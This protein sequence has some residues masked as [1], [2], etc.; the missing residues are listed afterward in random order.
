MQHE[1]KSLT[2]RQCLIKNN[3]SSQLLAGLK[4]DKAA[5][6]A[7]LYETQQFNS[8]LEQ[9][10]EQLEAENQDLILKK[11]HLQ[12]NHQEYYLSNT[13]CIVILFHTI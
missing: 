5:L 11:E 9:R 8:Q 6:E 10:R 2:D 13:F 4:S 3:Y 12:G 1:D 7:N